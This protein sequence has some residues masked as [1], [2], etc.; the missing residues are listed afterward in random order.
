M[1]STGRKNSAVK[2]FRGSFREGVGWIPHSIRL[3]FEFVLFA[4]Q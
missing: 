4:G 3:G 2:K 1:K